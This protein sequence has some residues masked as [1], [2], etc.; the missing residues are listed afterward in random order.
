[1][2]SGRKDKERRRAVLF[3]RKDA[4]QRARKQ[5][6]GSIEHGRRAL[7]LAQRA[8]NAGEL[9]CAKGIHPLVRNNTHTSCPI[10]GYIDFL[11]QTDDS[12]FVGVR[13][14]MGSQT[15]DEAKTTNVAAMGEPLGAVCSG[16]LAVGGARACALE[17]IVKSCSAAGPSASTCLIVPRLPSLH[18][19]QDELWELAL[20][21]ISRLTDPPKAG[22]AGRQNLSVRPFRR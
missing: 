16:P 5:F 6:G 8:A 11:E 1:M 19:L 12:R 20:L 17:R 14:P 10:Q 7:G 18:M 3:H 21:R 13:V 4:A 9:M 22:R 2:N 15:A